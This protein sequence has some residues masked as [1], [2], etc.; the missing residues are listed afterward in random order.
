MSSNVQLA[1]LQI[2]WGSGGSISDVDMA[3]PEKVKLL[4]IYLFDVLS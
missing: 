2:E 1:L 3:T 4:F